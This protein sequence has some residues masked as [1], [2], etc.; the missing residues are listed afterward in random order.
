[1]AHLWSLAVEEQFYIFWPFLMLLIKRELLPTVIIVFILIGIASQYLVPYNEFR[2]ILTF[3][4]FDAFGL[5]AFLSWVLLFKPQWLNNLY[6]VLKYLSIASIAI[7]IIAIMKRDLIVFLPTRTA[8]SIITLLIITYIIKFEKK[9]A[10]ASFVLDNKFLISIGKISYGLYL[11]HLPLPF[12]FNGYWHNL[13]NYL[14]FSFQVYEKYIIIIENFGLLL[15]ISWLSW[16]LIEKPALLLK[17]Y[18]E[19]GQS[20]KVKEMIPVITAT[21]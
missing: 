15:L 10:L 6:T 11:Y 12:F 5:G 16:R 17:K 19:Y 4:C 1:M 8:M 21:I 18:F 3:T 2:N 13:N 7:I 20:K 14:P 9:N